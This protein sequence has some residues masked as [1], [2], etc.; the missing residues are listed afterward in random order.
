MAKGTHGMPSVAATRACSRLKPPYMEDGVCGGSGTLN[1][2]LN[3][4]SWACVCCNLPPM[5]PRATAS[6]AGR[7]QVSGRRLQNHGG[8]VHAKGL[9]PAPVPTWLQ[10]IMRR[11]HE[12]TGVY[13]GAPPNHVLVNAYAPGQ[14]IMVRAPRS[15][16]ATEHAGGDSCMA[17]EWLHA[18][19]ILCSIFYASPVRMQCSEPHAR[20]A[21]CEC[22]ACRAG[23]SK[24]TERNRHLVTGVMCRAAPRPHVHT[25]CIYLPAMHI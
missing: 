7:A 10:P 11:M 17:L 5:A 19:E 25:P 22:V 4:S 15:I 18:C 14:G 3:H 20:Y 9:I 16:Q 13:G 8:I 6:A 23:V 12:A 1:T 2:T 21:K 24:T